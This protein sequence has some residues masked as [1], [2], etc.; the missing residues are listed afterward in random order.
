MILHLADAVKEGFRKILLRTVDTNV[1]VLAVAGAAEPFVVIKYLVVSKCVIW[2]AKKANN[3]LLLASIRKNCFSWY[4]CGCI[5]SPPHTPPTLVSGLG[6][7][8]VFTV[9]ILG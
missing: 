2:F 9:L 8:A 3:S 1:V 4:I 7:Q 6:L 5:N